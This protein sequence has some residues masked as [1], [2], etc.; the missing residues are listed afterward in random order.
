MSD[1]SWWIWYRKYL[2]SDA[3]KRK[4]KRVLKGAGYKCEVCHKAK[5]TNVHHLSYARVGQNPKRRRAREIMPRHAGPILVRRGDL[6]ATCYACHDK[7]HNGKLTQR[8]NG[9]K[10]L[11]W[12]KRIFK[13]GNSNKNK[14]R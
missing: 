2:Q 8:K 4:R 6:I 1:Q 9:K 3:W 14:P 7:L 11:P 12:W 13:H 5:A 10:K